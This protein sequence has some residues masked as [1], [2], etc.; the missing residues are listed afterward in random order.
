VSNHD[1]SL[2]DRYSNSIDDVLNQNQ[3]GEISRPESVQG[4]G[5]GNKADDLV[6]KPDSTSH[7]HSLDDMHEMQTPACLE[8]N[9]LLEA[10]ENATKGDSIS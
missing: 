9:A 4:V 8:E 10:A 3:E 1:R 2:Q 7:E 5:F 6:H